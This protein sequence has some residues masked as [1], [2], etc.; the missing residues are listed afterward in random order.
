MS[1][2]SMEDGFKVE[3]VYALFIFDEFIPMSS[4][5]WSSLL[6]YNNEVPKQQHFIKNLIKNRLVLVCLDRRWR[7]R[8][9]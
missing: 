4:M 6:L 7:V 2:N 3:R 5:G 8:D 9:I 1:N